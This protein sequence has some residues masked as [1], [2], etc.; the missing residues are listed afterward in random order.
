MPIRT[1]RASPARLV[2]FVVC[3]LAACSSAPDRRAAPPDDLA[4]ASARAVTASGAKL[5]TFEAIFDDAQR[6]DSQRVSFGGKPAP[7]VSWVDEKHWLATVTDPETKKP[8]RVLV[9]AATGATAPFAPAARL[10]TALRTIPGLDE[11]EM[12]RILSATRPDPRGRGQI[13]EVD[14]DLWLV[15]AQSDRALRLTSTPGATEEEP[16][17]SPDGQR[18][19]FVLGNDLWVAGVGLAEPKRL[20]T[21][22]SATV[23][24]GKLD[25]LYQEEV[26]GRGTFRSHWWSPDS[27]TLAYLRLDEAGVPPYTIVDD[28]TY[29]VG[30][31]TSP[32]PRAGEPNPTVALRVVDVATGAT[33]DVDL[34]RWKAD[35]PIVVNVHWSPDSRL[36]YQ[37]QDREQR[38][39]ELHACAA[40]A[41]GDALLLRETS[42]AWV[43]RGEI[44]EWL[45]DGTYLWASERT[46]WRHLYRYRGAELVNAVTSGEWEVRDL[47]G[48]DAQN[49]LV[50]FSGTERSHIGLDVYSV[51]LDGTGLKRLTER[52]GTHGAQ[53]NADFTL[54]EDSWSDVATPPQKRL[55]RA[56][57]GAELRVLDANPVPALAEYGFRPPELLQVKARDGFAMEA[58]RI[59][60][61]GYDPARR[62]PVMVFG[63]WGPHAPTVKNAWAG[64]N[65]MFQQLLAQKG[66]VVWSCDG[67][68]SSGKGAVSA[69]PSYQKLGE[70]EL[71]DLLDGV[72][73][74]VAQGV[75]DPARIGLTGWSYGGFM[76]SYALTHSGAFALGLAGG[77][78]TDWRNYDSI[79]TDRFMR[80]PKNNADGYARSSVVA[81]AAKVSG[82]LVLAHGGID[83]NVHPGNT[84]QLALALQKAEKPFDLMIYPGQRHGVGGAQANH[85]KRMQL[86]SIERWLLGPAR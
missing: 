71:A 7:G 56:S 85:W 50:Y 49:G 29:Q 68:T 51:K 35:E 64:T 59:L 78:V 3:A 22:G 39:L 77:S 36:H 12:A 15:S 21:D 79:Y 81:A 83:D 40:D 28:G 47:H 19:A 20:T 17:L 30:V 60:P 57:D 62:Y 86:E 70:H 11:K 82:R 42:P 52:P 45:A 18:V 61:P 23:L 67:R 73:W 37:V 1:Q 46:G 58:L 24:N 76:T 66:I 63:Y 74:L 80:T 2:P 13:V 53:F 33:K 25:W 9:D 26:Y 5:L 4:A 10:E 69:W 16:A 72:D 75:A 54:F 27:R 84:M 55:H 41:S 6:K 43:D 65:G 38:W 44:L 14:D 34:A 31:E 32:Y 8:K 48:V